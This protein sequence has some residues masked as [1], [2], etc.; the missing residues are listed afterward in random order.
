MSESV[1]VSLSASANRT[2]F[3]GCDG[4]VLT[5]SG[6][7][8]F[9]VLFDAVVLVREDRGP[10]GFGCWVALEFA[11]AFIGAPT[12]FGGERE[13][14][15]DGARYA[16]VVFV[17]ALG[18]MWKPRGDDVLPLFPPNEINGEV[19]RVRAWRREE[20]T[21]RVDGVDEWPSLFRRPI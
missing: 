2:F 14:R 15:E 5:R 13:D 4:L 16:S 17:A 6:L 18:E 3:T 1:S 10:F 12:L 19:P 9:V 20:S 21:L 11:I 7:A 8:S